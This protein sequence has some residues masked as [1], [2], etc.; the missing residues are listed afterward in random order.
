MRYYRFTEEELKKVLD[1]KDLEN[2]VSQMLNEGYTLVSVSY[3]GG[4]KVSGHHVYH[5]VK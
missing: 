5:F 2:A 1:K 4:C 3:V